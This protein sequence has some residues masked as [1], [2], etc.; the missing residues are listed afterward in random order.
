MKDVTPVITG[1]NDYMT[2]DGHTAEFGTNP[3]MDQWVYGYLNL[4]YNNVG[5]HAKR[6]QTLFD[7]Q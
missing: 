3:E 6:N 1:A 7:A 4:E 2:P 5:A